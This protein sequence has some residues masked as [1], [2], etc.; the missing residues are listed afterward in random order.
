MKSLKTIWSLFILI[1]I[2]P[3]SFCFAQYFKATETDIYHLKD[4]AG[5]AILYMDYASYVIK[6]TETWN[7]VNKDKQI[8]AVD[9]VFT[10]Y[11]YH[12]KDWITHYDSLL[13]NRIQQLAIIEPSILNSDIKW[14]LILQTNCK[15]E[16]EAKSMFHGAVFYYSTLLKPNELLRQEKIQLPLTPIMQ[17]MPESNLDVILSGNFTFHDSAIF[18]I[19]ERN[20]QWKDMLVVT[21]WTSS[22]YEY[23]SQVLLWHQLQHNNHRVKSMVF[24]NDG[25]RKKIKP[26]GKTGGIYFADAGEFTKT[27][28]TMKKV[29]KNGTGGDRSENDL[30]AI[31]TGM[32][33]IKGYK[34]VILIADSKSPVRDMSLLNQIN[35]PVRVILCGSREGAPVLHDYLKIAYKTGGSVHTIAEDVYNLHELQEGNRFSLLNVDY[36]MFQGRII[37]AKPKTHQG[38][39]T[40]F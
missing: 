16:P 8:V 39:A 20:P 23:G 33:K 21:D 15:T 18:K 27:V 37:K 26:V 7:N 17:P 40:I 3:S 2:L 30:E 10:R 24:F 4:S 5:K 38:Q 28:K 11:P 34:E 13:N 22:M 25:D 14:N 6:N 31:L 12:K 1:I 35:V 9:L 32:K 36:I 19:L 29:M